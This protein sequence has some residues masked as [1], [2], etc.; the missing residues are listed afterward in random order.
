MN[1]LLIPAILGVVVVVAAAF[2]L[3]PVEKVSTV[4]AGE[5]AQNES[6]RDRFCDVED[7]EIGDGVSDGDAEW[8]SAQR[9]CVLLED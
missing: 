8:D 7:D 1:R 6:F 2:S 3:M 4:H 9:D 5:S